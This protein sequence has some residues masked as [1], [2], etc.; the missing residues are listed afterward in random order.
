MGLKP[1]HKRSKTMGDGTEFV[2]AGLN[3]KADIAQ[4]QGFLCQEQKLAF[5]SEIAKL[6]DEDE[7]YTTAA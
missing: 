5:E 2:K 1:H 6:R 3:Y 4:W 7:R